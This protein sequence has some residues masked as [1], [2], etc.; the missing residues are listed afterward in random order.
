MADGGV[1]ITAATVTI[2]GADMADRSRICPC[3]EKESVE[4]SGLPLKR[5]RPNGR[6]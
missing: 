2:T 6:S 3:L 1:G 4:M 5:T